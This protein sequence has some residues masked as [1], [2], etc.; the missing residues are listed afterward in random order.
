MLLIIY[1]KMFLFVC[2]LIFLQNHG[3]EVKSMIAK[4]KNILTNITHPCILPIIFRYFYYK[5]NVLRSFN[6]KQGF[7][8]W[9]TDI[10]ILFINIM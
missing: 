8:V 5:N 4:N 9:V 7:F 6:I 2:L 1:F 3:F 10:S